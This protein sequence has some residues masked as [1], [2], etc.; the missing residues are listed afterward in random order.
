[1]DLSKPLLK[2]YHWWKGHKLDI[3][4]NSSDTCQDLDASGI[5]FPSKRFSNWRIVVKK[6][7]DMD[8]DALERIQREDKTGPK[9]TRK[10]W[11]A[12]LSG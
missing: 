6:I 5:G 9:G 3:Y 1:M 11:Y 7:S 4:I 12:D 8:K 2:V 10:E